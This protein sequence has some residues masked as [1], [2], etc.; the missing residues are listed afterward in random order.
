[1][2]TFEQL[3]EGQKK[4][5]D[6]VVNL[7]KNPGS[8]ST[9]H[10]T[11][12]GPAGTGKTTLTK[13][14]IDYL[15]STGVTGIA[16]AAPTHGAKK[17]LSKLSG[18]QASTIHSLSK[19]NPTT[20]EENVLFEQKKTPDMASIRVLICD[21]ASMYDRKLFKILMA[22]IPRWCVV[23][24][25]GDKFQIR[26]V[27]PGSNEPSVSPFFTHNAFMQLHLDEVKRSNTPIIEVATEIRNGNWIY[28]NIIDGHGVKGFTS[29]TALKD[30]MLNYFDIVKS[31]D[32][33]FENRMLAYTNKSVDKLNSIIRRKIYETDSPFVVGE[34]IVMQE[35]L[36]KELEFEGKKFSEILFN[37]GQF[38]RIVDAKETTSFLNAIGV[39]GEYL[40]RHWVLDIETYDQD[41]DY[42][43][44]TIQ[45]ISSEEENNKFQFFL[46]KTADTYKNWNKGGK[47]PWKS[48]WAQRR[49]F[50]KVKA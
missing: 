29:Q 30:F 31:Q 20:Y 21:E 10:V 6:F 37:N 27:E 25:I 4:A 48:F 16:L 13:F 8:L 14:I 49:R 34:V 41:D 43:R 35:P 36:I 44:E 46:A 5:F 40:I 9:R 47:A 50:H 24:A 11:I 7:I 22:S 1:M 26:P 2:I 32:D 33:F 15:I 23:I 3:T 39:S 42:Y 17:V 19:I 38:V 12:N 45:V 18:M 28:D